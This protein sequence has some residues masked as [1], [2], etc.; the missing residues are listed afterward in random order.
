MNQLFPISHIHD[1]KYTIRQIESDNSLPTRSKFF[2]TFS[3][4]SV[5]DSPYLDACGMKTSKLISDALRAES[6]RIQIER[7]S[8]SNV[9]I[10]H[11]L[12]AGSLLEEDGHIQPHKVLRR[13]GAEEEPHRDLHDRLR[14]VEGSLQQVGRVRHAGGTHSVWNSSHHDHGEGSDDGTHHDVQE[15]T[16][17]E[18]HDGCSLHKVEAH[19]HHNEVQASESGLDDNEELPIVPILE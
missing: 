3:P 2:D 14:E 1:D 6:Y 15:N 10:Q 13:N 19:G 4:L 18:A 17:A 8:T 5:D 11:S 12:L 16:H 9:R 7:K